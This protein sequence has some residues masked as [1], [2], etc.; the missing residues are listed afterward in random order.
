MKSENQNSLD[1]LIEAEVKR[2]D[3][4]EKKRF[5]YDTKVKISKGKIEKYKMMK[6]SQNFISLSDMLL[7]KGIAFED[8]LEAISSGDILAL[9]EK[10]E[11]NDIPVDENPGIV[12][13]QDNNT[14]LPLNV[15]LTQSD[16]SPD[17]ISDEDAAV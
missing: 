11:Q 4:Y 17:A 10:L 13:E 6:N 7:N 5:E 14:D 9:Q 8:V 16:T 1:Q 15:S 12:N 2:L 3:R